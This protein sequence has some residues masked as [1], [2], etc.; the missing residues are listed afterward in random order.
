[1][2]PSLILFDLD[3][4]LLP[5]DQ[6]EF[7]GG[8]FKMLCKK[9]A[10]YGYDPQKLVAGIW[11]GT[12]AM[13]K[14]DGSRTNEEAFWDRFCRDFG[15]KALEHKDIFEEFYAV[16]FRQ[17]QKFCGFNP[18]AAQTVAVLKQQGYR[19]ALA[20]NPIFPAIATETR[21]GWAGLKPSDFELYTTYEN[22]RFS[23]PNPAYYREI[24]K[25]LGA[26]PEETL[27]V[28]NDVG[29]D[30]I[31]R[32]LGC[33]VFLL[34]DCIINKTDLNPAQFPNGSF[35]ELLHFLENLNS[36]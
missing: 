13:V 16:E 8:Y 20:T 34:T 25:E 21:I 26:A 14:N 31:A 3:G 33:Q 11:A 19:I 4:T 18:M 36:L 22:S 1:M 30:M 6:D 27:M 15:T 7:V 9:L 23:K 10:P 12:A 29:E 32:E 35:G 5:M 2:K 24:L 17:A 28:G